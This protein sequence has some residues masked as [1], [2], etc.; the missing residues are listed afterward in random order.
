MKL[1]AHVGACDECL[2]DCLLLG[3]R[4]T[5]AGRRGPPHCTAAS[6]QTHDCL[7]PWRLCACTACST[8]PVASCRTCVAVSLY[9]RT[10]HWPTPATRAGLIQLAFTLATLC[11]G[12]ATYF[13]CTLATLWQ[14]GRAELRSLWGRGPIARFGVG[15]ATAFAGQD[16]FKQE[17]KDSNDG[18]ANGHSE[19]GGGSCCAVLYCC[20]VQGLH[21]RQHGIRDA[22]NVCAAW[23]PLTCLDR[24]PIPPP[25]G[26]AAL[27]CAVLPSHQVVKFGVPLYLGAR[28]QCE[29]LPAQQLRAALAELAAAGPL[30]RPPGKDADDDAAVRAD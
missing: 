15:R 26:R 18:R 5:R 4:S 25:S 22:T 30:R 10:C 24:T 3:L 12:A 7:H 27:T 14:V 19:E 20:G 9:V 8:P 17:R 6:P 28:H 23:R 21:C 11:I 1:L 13:S 16:P 29:R 2:R